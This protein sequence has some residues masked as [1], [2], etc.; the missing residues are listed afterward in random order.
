[1]SMP[2]QVIER[3]PWCTVDVQAFRVVCSGDDPHLVGLPVFPLVHL[4]HALAVV[5]VLTL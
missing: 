4:S 3:G 1:M 5:M 2:H